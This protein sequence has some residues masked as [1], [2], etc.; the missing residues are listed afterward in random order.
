MYCQFEKLNLDTLNYMSAA[1]HLYQQAGFYEIAPY[2]PNP[3]STAVCFE[4]EMTSFFER[5]HLPQKDVISK[6]FS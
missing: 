4:M 2:Y 5:C 6:V 1:I 3:I